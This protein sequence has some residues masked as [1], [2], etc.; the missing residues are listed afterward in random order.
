MCQ[1]S[2]VSLVAGVLTVLLEKRWQSWNNEPVYEDY[3]F[4]QV[5]PD[6][7]HDLIFNLAKIIARLRHATQLISDDR[8]G[9]G[10]ERYQFKNYLKTGA[11]FQPGHW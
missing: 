4:K 11:R 1:L 7:S 5:E 10:H 9:I 6:L 3:S 8:W 2:P